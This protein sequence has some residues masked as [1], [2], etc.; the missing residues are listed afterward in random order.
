MLQIQKPRDL[1]MFRRCLMLIR[2]M[3][4]EKNYKRF[5]IYAKYDGSNGEIERGVERIIKARNHLDQAINELNNLLKKEDNKYIQK[6]NE[7]NKDREDKI[8][9][10]LGRIIKKLDDG[11][12]TTLEALSSDAKTRRAYNFLSKMG[13]I[14]SSLIFLSVTKGFENCEDKEDNKKIIYKV[15]L[16]FKNLAKSLGSKTAQEVSYTQQINKPFVYPR[17]PRREIESEEEKKE[18]KE[19]ESHLIEEEEDENIENIDEEDN[20]LEERIIED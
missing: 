10:Y 18:V 19:P 1:S 20:V 9:E 13:K 5:Y 17:K 15:Y 16:E 8:E 6:D 12:E 11:Q 4:I 7:E 2:G 3:E 14:M